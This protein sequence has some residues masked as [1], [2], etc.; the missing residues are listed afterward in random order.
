LLRLYSKAVFNT[1]DK[2]LTPRVTLVRLRLDKSALK[3]EIQPEDSPF[4]QFILRYL[5]AQKRT[6]STALYNHKEAPLD[7]LKRQIHVEITGAPQFSSHMFFITDLVLMDTWYTLTLVSLDRETYNSYYR[8]SGK[9]D[10]AP[11]SLLDAVCIEFASDI[12]KFLHQFGREDYEKTLDFQSTIRN[13][14]KKLLKILG[15]SGLW[16]TTYDKLNKIS[17]LNYEGKAIRGRILFT[18]KNILNKEGSHPN[19]DILMTFA[20]RTPLSN[21][22]HVR[23]LLELSKGDICLIS[24]SE[25]IYGLG[26]KR[27]DYKLSREDLFEIEFTNYYTWV[28]LHDSQKLMR[29]S[30]EHISLPK[31][32]IEYDQFFFKLKQIYPNLDHQ[33][34][35]TLYLL[36]MEAIR[37]NT[38]TL[39]VF[40]PNAAS[41]AKRLKNQCFQVEAIPMTKDIIRSVINIDGAILMDLE[42]IC[43]GIGAILDGMASIRGDT[44]R[45]ARYNS[46]IRYVETIGKVDTY[47]DCVAVVISDDGFIDIITKYTI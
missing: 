21:F 33:K 16:D 29:V 12:N 4:S 24:D 39:I 28:L 45:G 36:V 34:I 43:H 30:H 3:Y 47:S 41:E 6:I 15:Y 37:Y 42:G 18:R 17:S 19:L 13:G 2:N 31:A 5:K 11:R 35:R 10:T 23:K 32:K 27:G 46:A 9:S 14:S 26:R 8:L 20:A 7:A 38:G 22:R 40:T 1:F 44:A 25:S